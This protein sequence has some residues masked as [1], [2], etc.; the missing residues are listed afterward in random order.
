MHQPSGL[1]LTRSPRKERFFELSLPAM[2]KGTD[3]QER[4]FSE[5][6]RI[7]HLSADEVTFWLRAKVMIGTKL[8]LSL[9]IPKTFLLETPLEVSLS[10]S[11]CFVKSDMS[12]VKKNQLISIKLDKNYQILS[13]PA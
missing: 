9:T 6:T 12:V 3:A 10:G 1:V 11:V 5:E 7:S 8:I 2:V 4:E 13:R